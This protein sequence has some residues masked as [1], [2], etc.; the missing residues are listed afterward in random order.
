MAP[1]SKASF[2]WCLQLGYRLG[3]YGTQEVRKILVDYCNFDEL[4]SL[5]KYYNLL[6]LSLLLIDQFTT[7][8][9][10]HRKILPGS[11]GEKAF[12]GAANKTK[13]TRFKRDSNGK[14]DERG[15]YNDDEV[16]TTKC[17]YTNEAWFS[18]GVA[19]VTPIVD[20]VPQQREGRRYKPFVYTNRTLLSIPDYQ[21]K[22]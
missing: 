15:T 8:D 18:L 19:M 6:Y 17:K 10:V 14:I 11:D 13:A 20:G 12:V 5:P 22:I 7:W 16:Y 21:K 2:G 9:E 4:T 3:L 1:N